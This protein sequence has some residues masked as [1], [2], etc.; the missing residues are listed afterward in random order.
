MNKFPELS[1]V[2]MGNEEGLEYLVKRE[3]FEMKYPA[4]RARQSSNK[5]AW[6]A[7]SK[8]P[9]L[10]N[11]KP[12]KTPE[13]NSTTGTEETKDGES[14]EEKTENVV[15]ESTAKEDVVPSRPQFEIHLNESQV[16]ALNE[17]RARRERQRGISPK[18]T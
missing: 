13:M 12:T 11:A 7:L 4:K 15:E 3:E 5:A 1:S 16:E 14:N 9:T 6:R 10:T 8:Q 17:I 18:K 2:D